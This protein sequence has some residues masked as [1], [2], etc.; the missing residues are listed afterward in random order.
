M[1]SRLTSVTPHRPSTG[2]STSSTP[3]CAKK[4]RT[5]AS[6]CARLSRAA[7]EA[8]GCQTGSRVMTGSTALHPADVFAGAGIN[9]DA[10][11]GINHLQFDE[12]GGSYRQRRA[13]VQSNRVDILLFQ[14]F[15]G[16]ANGLGIGRV[17]PEGAISEHEVPEFTVGIEVFHVL[18]NHIRSFQTFAVLERALPDP[19]GHEVTQP[20]AVEGLPLT[21]FDKLVLENDAG[22][23]IQQNLKTAAK[24]VG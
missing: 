20:Y 12:I 5:N 24:F 7:C 4:P 13:V 10:R 14:P 3:L 16:I 6:C 21:G 2:V 15:Q 17:L 9:L 11:I 22:V 8:E 1:P 19:V 18:I 23:A